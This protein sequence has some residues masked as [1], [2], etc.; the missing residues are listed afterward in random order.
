MTTKDTGLVDYDHGIPK[1]TTGL[2]TVNI[3]TDQ[4]VTTMT[5]KEMAGKVVTFLDEVLRD[6]IEGGLPGAINSLRSYIDNSIPLA[7][8]EIKTEEK[9][10]TPSERAVQ[11][12]EEL[13]FE[14][15]FKKRRKATIVGEPDSGDLP[16][17]NRNGWRGTVIGGAATLSGSF[18][19]VFEEITPYFGMHFVLPKHIKFETD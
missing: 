17:N 9:T 19:Y 14:T 11:P 7:E 8:P 5:T 2:P 6:A 3:M 12:D 1:A 10:N 4:G 13:L 18:Y 15:A 16:N